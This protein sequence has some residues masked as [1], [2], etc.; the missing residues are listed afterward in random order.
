MAQG[1][2]A[3]E[4]VKDSADSAQELWWKIQEQDH[5]AKATELAALERSLIDK[6]RELAEREAQIGAL[7]GSVIDEGSGIANQLQWQQERM[8]R[9]QSAREKLLM[10]QTK[11]AEAKVEQERKR[12]QDHEQQVQLVALA[13]VDEERKRYDRLLASQET[14]L[15]EVQEKL[16]REARASAENAARE[17][18]DAKA[19]ETLK[20]A[21]NARL[22]ESLINGQAEM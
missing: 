17:V 20:T 13:A 2:S 10:D 12:I 14:Q 9:E 6:A 7:R 5:N 8:A 18:S 16:L 21:L 3:L 19:A 4:P 1:E 22:S 11:E 15:G